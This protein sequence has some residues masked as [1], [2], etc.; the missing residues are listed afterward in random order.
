VESD[1]RRYH[2][3]EADKERIQ[4]RCLYRTVPAGPLSWAAAS[5]I[6]R[7]HAKQQPGQDT[8]WELAD[9]ISC[10]FRNIFQNSHQNRHSREKKKTAF[11]GGL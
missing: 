1:E 11:W 5:I 2:P 10:K 4:N 7:S 6:A 9:A 8:V 3:N